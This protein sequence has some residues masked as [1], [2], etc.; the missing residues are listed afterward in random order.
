M[1]INKFQYFSN[2]DRL[3]D[4]K[5]EATQRYT[6]CS[7]FEH[8]INAVSSINNGIFNNLP[9]SERVLTDGKISLDKINRGNS[10]VIWENHL[11]TLED[12]RSIEIKIEGATFM[13]ASIMYGEEVH[14]EIHTNQEDN[15][16]LEKILDLVYKQNGS[17]I[18]TSS[19]TFKTPCIV[20]FENI[21]KGKKG[22]E[23]LN[24]I[25][26]KINIRK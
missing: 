1:S 3:R 11:L 7:F 18:E 22:K 10:Y 2:Y 16:L 8:E 20:S 24:L 19:V 23:E 12:G 4:F 26:G 9:I 25:T 13:V 17:S 14:H 5:M 15:L 6:N 21:I